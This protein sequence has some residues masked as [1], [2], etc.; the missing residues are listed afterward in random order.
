MTAPR[1]RTTVTPDDTSRASPRASRLSPHTRHTIALCRGSCACFPGQR[2]GAAPHWR[3]A[4]P[5]R[6]EAADRRAGK[7][8]ILR[9]RTWR[10]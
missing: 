5:R 3:A 10:R 6:A 7:K 1:T 8:G 9:R 2:P 4:G